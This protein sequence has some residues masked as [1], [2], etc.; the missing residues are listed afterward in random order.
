MPVTVDARMLT[1]QDV[2]EADKIKLTSLIDG[3][4]GGR[5]CH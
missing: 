1:V 5:K 4:K 3:N 2:A